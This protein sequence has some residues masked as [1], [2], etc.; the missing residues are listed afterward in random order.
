MLIL[1]KTRIVGGPEFS[2]FL[3]DALLFAFE[4]DDVQ[5][6]GAWLGIWGSICFD[7]ALSSRYSAF[8]DIY[9]HYTEPAL[10]VHRRVLE[11]EG[12]AQN[13]SQ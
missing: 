5:I 13:G 4:I 2:D 9:N 8:Y 1:L 11:A 3:E 6:S 7:D 10:D 12:E